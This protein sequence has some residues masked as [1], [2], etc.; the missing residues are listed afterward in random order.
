MLVYWNKINKI[1]RLE[2]FINDIIKLSSPTL[3]DIWLD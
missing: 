1:E 3:L 2:K